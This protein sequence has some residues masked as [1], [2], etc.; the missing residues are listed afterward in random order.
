MIPREVGA[1]M[2]KWQ[3]RGQWF[4]PPDLKIFAFFI[5]DFFLIVFDLPICLFIYCLIASYDSLYGFQSGYLCH[6]TYYLLLVFQLS[7]LM[8]AKLTHVLFF[9]LFFFPL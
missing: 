4:E 3:A 8:S 6:V 2:E 5:S 9:F 1:D 7:F